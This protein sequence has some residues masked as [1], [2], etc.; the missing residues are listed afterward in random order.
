MRRSHRELYDNVSIDEIP[1]AF[2]DEQHL[3]GVMT[4]PAARP[5]SVAVMFINAGV[6]N[7]VGPGRIN[8]KIARHLAAQGY[9]AVRVDLSGLGDSRVP[10]RASQ[11][12][13]QAVRDIQAVIDRLVEEHDIAGVAVCGMCSGA[14]NAYAAALADRRIAGVFLFDGYAYATRASRLRRQLGR[15]LSITPGKIRWRVD[16]L[17]ARLRG[18]STKRDAPR[19]PL[20]PPPTHDEF[21]GAMQQLVDRGVRVSLCFSSAGGC[22][23]ADQMRDAFRRHRFIRQIACHYVPDIDHLVT[24]LIAQQRFT[25]LVDDWVASIPAGH[26]GVAVDRGE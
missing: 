14:E 25:A 10:A 16:K 5:K 9:C 13:Q 17:L 6:I 7:R 15:M 20:I 23:Y 2:G 19:A 3:L 21:A 22:W 4:A 24:P 8:V 11:F 18:Q 12:G 1:V 26:R